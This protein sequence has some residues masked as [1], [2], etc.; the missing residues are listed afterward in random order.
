MSDILDTYCPYCDKPVTAPIEELNEVYTVRNKPIAITTRVPICPYC[1]QIIGDC[2]TEG[3]NLEL[4]YR[5]Y[6]K[7]Y[8]EN[9]RL[10]IDN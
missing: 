6:E 1:E 10:Q 4:A 9:P 8:G 3:A 5:T 2:R 7:K